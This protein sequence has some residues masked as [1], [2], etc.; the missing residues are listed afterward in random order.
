L[1]FEFFPE[2]I[3]LCDIHL[4]FIDGDTIKVTY[5]SIKNKN[6][7]STKITFKNIITNL[8]YYYHGLSEPY[9]YEN[10]G[11]IISIVSEYHYENFKTLDLTIIQKIK[12]Y[13]RIGDYKNLFTIYL[14][15]INYSKLKF[16]NYPVGDIILEINDILITDINIFKQVIKNPIKKF[17]TINN[18]VYFI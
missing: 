7:L 2:K 13:E 15:D 17:K 16:T 8:P 5:Y 3:E 18:E 10:N 11:L 4:W 12:I 6:Y 1:K 9:Y 14:S